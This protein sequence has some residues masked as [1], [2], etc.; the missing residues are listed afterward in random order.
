M[1]K[2]STVRDIEYGT[3]GSVS[4]LLDV[5]S[6]D[7]SAETDAARAAIVL[8]HGGGWFRGDK[9]KEDRKSVV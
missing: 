4:L 3:A 1:D 5:Y 7:I 9:S 8:V 2:Q 6:R